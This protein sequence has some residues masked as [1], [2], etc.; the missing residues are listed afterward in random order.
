MSVRGISLVLLGLLLFLPGRGRAESFA[1]DGGDVSAGVS[2]GYIMPRGYYGANFNSGYGYGALVQYYPDSQL[3][4]SFLGWRTFFFEGDLRF[5]SF[6]MKES[7]ESRLLFYAGG[8]GPVLYYPLSG[9]LYPFVGINAGV[10]Y[11]RLH[12]ENTDADAVSTNVY[13]TLK[14]GMMLPLV[15]YT[16]LRVDAAYS[17]YRMTQPLTSLGYNVSVAYQ[18]SPTALLAFAGGKEGKVR[19][20]KVDFDD[21]FAIHYL[22]YNRKGIG[23]ITIKNTG[24]GNLQDVCIETEISELMDMAAP[25]RKIDEIK[26]GESVRFLIPV[27][28]SQKVLQVVEDRT[29]PVRFKVLCKSRNTLLT[30]TEHRT[31]LIHNKNALIWSDPARLA[32]FIMPKE[33]SVSTLARNI[34]SKHRASLRR[35]IPGK[36]QQAMQLFNALGALGISYVSDPLSIRAL[37]NRR[38]S[39]VDYVQIPRETLLKKAGDCD[40][41]TS[42]YASLLESVGI[43]T[44]VVAVPGHVLLVFDTEIPKD[45]MPE[46]GPERGDCIIRNGTVWVPVE[47]TL[48]GKSFME[49]WKKGAQRI[50]SFR[51]DDL[52]VTETEY[53]WQEYPPADLGRGEGMLPVPGSDLQISI[54]RDADAL[55]RLLYD[56]PLVERMARVRKDPGSFRGW[57]SLGVLYGRNSEADRAMKC[58]RK[59]VS[60]KADYAPAYTNM[61]NVCMLKGEYGKALQYYKKSLS[62]NPG[63]FRARINLARVY[64]E[65][66]DY[67]KASEEYERVVAGRPEYSRRYSYLK[68]RRP[69]SGEKAFDAGERIEWNVWSYDA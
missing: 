23:S 59:A 48:A 52:A 42:L 60:L 24:Q 14:A 43:H 9:W 45:S 67:D 63:S 69:E 35:G 56:L 2:A 33:E 5:S 66:K 51:R 29:Y 34:L 1:F 64:Y 7:P 44:A 21:L 47:T 4:G 61:G 19:V 22:R 20:E 49:A 57:N 31:V 30:Y 41:L 62:I 10:F 11:S 17:Y 32:S 13:G 40:D 58:F 39:I 3:M 18:F 15:H 25:S 46:L 27:V 28:F 12:L 6:V 53:A 65:L 50:K 36:L 38:E 26:P 68:K 37:S 55:R 8:L 16:S 54:T